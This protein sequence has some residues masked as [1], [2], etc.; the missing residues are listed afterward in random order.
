MVS[1]ADCVYASAQ[2]PGDT[3]TT[4]AKE[5]EAAAQ[6]EAERKAAEDAAAAEAAAEEP[7]L[8]YSETELRDNARV[9]LDVS[10]HAIAPIFA[11]SRKKTL[12]LD[13]AKKLAGEF[14]KREVKG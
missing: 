11:K 8:R 5:R 10:P 6:A 9:L 7:E 4:Q 14:V 12:T 1:A 3:Q 13:E 2:M